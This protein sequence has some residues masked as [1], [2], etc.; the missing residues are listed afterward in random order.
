MVENN[1]ENYPS[2]S[3]TDQYSAIPSPSPPSSPSPREK[4]PGGWQS[5]KYILGISMNY[6]LIIFV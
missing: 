3:S 2:S 6:I 5:V 4:K 1:G